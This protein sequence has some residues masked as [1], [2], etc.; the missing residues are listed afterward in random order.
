VRL[1]Q[2]SDRFDVLRRK[3]VEFT[4][5]GDGPQASVRL[6]S[7]T[8]A[9]DQNWLGEFFRGREKEETKRIKRAMELAW[10][11]NNV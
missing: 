2:E 9:S 4:N 8:E 3:T 10:P 11:K 1:V 7:L 6:D 5:V